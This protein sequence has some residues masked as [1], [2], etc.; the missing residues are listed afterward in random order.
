MRLHTDSLQDF[1]GKTSLRLWTLLI[2]ANGEQR[3]I[4]IFTPV[5]PYMISSANGKESKLRP[6]FLKKC[7]VLETQFR[8]LLLNTVQ[9]QF[10]DFLMEKFSNV[11][12]MN[13]VEFMRFLI[14][15]RYG[16]SY[17]DLIR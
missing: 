6:Y 12:N 17:D 2:H 16:E 11:K 15:E 7:K 4:L 10:E 13:E 5:P 14:N 3:M 8:H 1:Q 9:P